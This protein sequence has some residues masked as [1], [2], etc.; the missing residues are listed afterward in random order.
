MRIAV[1]DDSKEIVEQVIGYIDRFSG[2]RYDIK[3]KRFYL[4]ED[5]MDYY[6][7]NGNTF[8]ILITDIEFNGT[9][10]GIELASRV[11]N[12]DEEVVIFFL[13]S[14]SHYAIDCFNARPFNFWRKPLEYEALEFDLSL[15]FK[16]LCR[17]ND[18]IDIIA[19]KE[20]KRIKY[21]DILYIEKKGRKTVF[22]TVSGD[23]CA[24]ISLS[25]LETRLPPQRFV[26][27]YQ[28][29][30]IDITKVEQHHKNQ[31][32]IKGVEEELEIGR[33]FMGTFNRRYTRYKEGL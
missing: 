3:Y 24:N 10:N 1:C 2:G 22:H 30:I 8:D 4:A 21:S 19:R 20:N 5:A 29:Y 32:K 28:S 27:I 16:Q 14:H 15:A 9:M 7:M 6:K 17:N 18:F 12:R 26:R 11:R 23:L 13:T 33:T 25:E 31:V